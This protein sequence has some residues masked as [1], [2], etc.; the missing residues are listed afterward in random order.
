MINIYLQKTELLPGD[1]LQGQCQ[2][3]PA[4]KERGKKAQLTIGWRT[5]GRGSVD[6]E[7]L[8]KIQALAPEVSNP[9]RCQIP[10]NAPYSYDGELI[11]IIWEVRV[12]IGKSIEIKPFQVILLTPS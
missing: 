5:E 9:F 2:W 8:F 6:K 1:W 11:R 3:Y 10:H 4:Q 7:V 12:E